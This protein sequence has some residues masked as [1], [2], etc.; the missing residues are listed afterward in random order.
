MEFSFSKIR[1]SGLE[2]DLRAYALSLGEIDVPDPLTGAPVRTKR[3]WLWYLDMVSQSREAV[4]ALWAGLVNSPPRPAVLYTESDAPNTTNSMWAY[5]APA[6]RA[7]SFH[8]KYAALPKVRAHQ[9]VVVPD[10]AY[11]RSNFKNQPAKEEVETAL[12]YQGREFLLLNLPEWEAGAN[13]LPRLYYARL[14]ALSHLPLKAEW[15]DWLW[16]YALAKELLSPLVS[17]G[18]EAWLGRIPS[19]QML[20]LALKAALLKEEI[21]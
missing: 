6:E 2:A 21:S 18:C 17:Y 3:A 16:H 19:D 20:A 13:L 8:W 7:G 14:D 5:L 10:C 9:G 4:K 11:F 12:P 15:A 1:Q